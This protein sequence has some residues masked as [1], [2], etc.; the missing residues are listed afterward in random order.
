[1]GYGVDINDLGR[2]DAW[3]CW[4]CGGPVAPDSPAGSPLAASVD[5]V[6]PRAR[7]DWETRL[8]A[9][10]TRLSTLALRLNR[11]AP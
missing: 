2:R 4:V 11:A 8:Q 10:G 1:M 5:H 3:A 7:G 9:L 6:I